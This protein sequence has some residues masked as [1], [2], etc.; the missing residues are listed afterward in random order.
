MKKSIVLIFLV[1]IITFIDSS[2]LFSQNKF[3]IGLSILPSYNYNSDVNFGSFDKHQFIV[4]F[5]LNLE[6]EIRKSWSIIFRPNF[7]NKQLFN[8]CIDTITI[9]RTSYSSINPYFVSEKNCS[10]EANNTHSFIEFPFG[11]KYQFIQSKKAKFKYYLLL[12]N[13]IVYQIKR[14]DSVFDKIRNKTS[15]YDSYPIQLVSLFS[16]LIGLGYELNINN[17]ITFFSE[18]NL[19]TV[20]PVFTNYNLGLNFG[21]NCSL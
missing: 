14:E 10:F 12:G 5:G 20:N 15:I 6:Y 4:P 11:V 13:A 18:I 9:P 8:K 17:K 16:P 1:N 3:Q 21:L 2:S 19:K 7:Y